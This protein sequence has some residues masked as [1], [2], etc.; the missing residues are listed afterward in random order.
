M[1]DRSRIGF[2]TA[3][4]SVVVSPWRVHLFRKATGDSDTGPAVPPTFLK[5]METEHCSSAA[6]L[7]MLGIGLKGVLHA[8]QEFNHHTP[9]HVGETVTVQ[10][11][12]QSVEE[13]KAGALTFIVIETE[14]AVL[15]SQVA[16]SRQTIV[17]RRME[18]KA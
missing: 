7:K 17:S 13:K 2:T 8:E 6:L 3:P 1:I 11:R 16:T 18:S 9:V 15:G 14:Y 10:R 5:A 12:I 4:T